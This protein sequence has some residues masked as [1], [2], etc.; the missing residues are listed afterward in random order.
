MGVEMG[1]IAFHVA[2]LAEVPSKGLVVPKGKGWRATSI[3]VALTLYGAPAAL[4]QNCSDFSNAIIQN[5]GGTAAAATASASAIA[6]ALGNISTAFLTQQ[7]SAFVAGSTSA[8]PDQPSGGIWSRA[9]GGT[10]ETKSTT[11][12]L[13]TETD[14]LLPGGV[15][16]VPGSCNSQVK[17]DF[18]GFQAGMDIARL[19]WNGWNLHVGLTGGYLEAKGEDLAPGAVKS[20]FQVPF[21]GGYA[22]ATHGRFFS[23]VMVRREFYNVTLNQP[24]LN[25]HNQ[26]I[27]A[28]S[29]SVSAGAGYNFDLQEGWFAEPSAGLI[30][31][32]AAVDS[33]TL[34]GPTLAGDPPF[35]LPGTLSFN[36]IDSLIGRATLRVGKNFTANGLALQP[37]AS[38]SVFHEFAG[39]ITSNFVSCAGC[40][41]FGGGPGPTTIVVANETSRVGTYGQFSLGLAAQVIDTGWIG[42]V[43]GDYRKGENI[44]G[45]SASA[46]L[47]YNFVPESPAPRGKMVVKAKAPVLAALYNWSGLYV[48]GH[49]GAAQGR[50]HVEFVG[51]GVSAEPYASGYLLGGQAGYNVQVGQFVFGVEGEVSATNLTGTNACGTSPGRDPVT[52]NITGFSPLFLTCKTDLDW[53]ATAA[54]RFGA[55]APWSDRTVFYVKAG[56]AFS[57]EEVTV[58]CIFGPVND[59]TQGNSCRG[60]SGAATNGFSGSDSKFGGLIGVGTEFGLTRD[61]SAKAEITYIRFRDEEITASDGGRLSI[62]AGFAQAKIGVNY[63]FGQLP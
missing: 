25:L 7:T 20:E 32:R 18:A 24:T 2:K 43:R 39:N 58:G 35:Q 6:G 9:V 57:H 5:L 33:F 51:T 19:N 55:V 49:F 56:G 22:V 27:G 37:F 61:W 3:A 40:V 15:V 21:I 4:A 36:N 26:S 8:R 59:P 13:V 28:R 41:F 54:V 44:E 29:W 17:L 31:S 45:V 16:R 14:P 47:R 11:S 52:G 34:V 60:P 12:A 46:G 1:K 10:V 42:F 30:W 53:L 50:G 38:A 62:G 48:G 23:D 63:R